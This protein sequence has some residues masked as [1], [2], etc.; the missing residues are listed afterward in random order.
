M[1]EP[2]SQH[3]SWCTGLYKNRWGKTVQSNNEQK[4]HEEGSVALRPHPIEHQ[5][6][7][8][9]GQKRGR[10]EIEDHGNDQPRLHAGET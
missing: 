3:Q 4:S 7:Y 8:I 2:A 1:A 6:W 9:E 5:Y 10:E